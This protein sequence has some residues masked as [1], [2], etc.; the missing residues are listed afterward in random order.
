[1]ST[2]LVLVPPSEGKAPGG[3]GAWQAD[4]GDFGDLAP[5]RHD[6]IDALG[7]VPAAS[8]PKVSGASGA[9][10]ERAA[11]AARAL[12]EGAAPS[13]PSWQR[14]TGVVWEHL[15]PASLPAPARRRIIVP[16]ALLGLTRGTDPAPDFRLKFSVS[17]PGIGRLDRWWRP[18]LTD[19]LRRTSGPVL[20]LLPNEHAAAL[21]LE[22]LGGRVRR[23]S[24]I[25]RGGA[26]VGH[27][28]KAVKGHVARVA[29]LDG[30][31]A[32]DELCWSGWEARRESPASVVVVRG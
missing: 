9:L 10:A 6:V 7:R 14:F 22:V 5:R 16:S 13:M 31:D 26:A 15:D 12:Q 28:A 25:D 21:D 8:W 19:A 24:F 29:L 30:I 18:A 27:D 17:V 20:D 1:M 4:A 2:V 3:R 23:V 11:Q 32:L